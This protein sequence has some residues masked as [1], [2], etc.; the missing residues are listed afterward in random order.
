MRQ[1]PSQ[2][3]IPPRAPVSSWFLA[4]GSMRRCTGARVRGSV[5]VRRI[6]DG[7]EAPVAGLF[8]RS[9]T[10][11]VKGVRCVTPAASTHVSVEAGSAVPSARR[12]W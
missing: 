3:G 6:R 4:S 5:V 10:S 8:Q 12:S 7:Y 11:R 2:Y 9:R 1:A